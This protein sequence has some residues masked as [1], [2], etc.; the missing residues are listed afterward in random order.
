MVL[1]STVLVDIDLVSRTGGIGFLLHVLSEGPPELAP[2]LASVFLYIADYPRTREYLQVGV[3][4]EVGC[5]FVLSP[6]PDTMDR[7]RFPI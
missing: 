5:T 7:L 6:C 2:I 3:D 1:L 4:L